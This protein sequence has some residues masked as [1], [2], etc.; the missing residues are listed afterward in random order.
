MS[1][2]IIYADDLDGTEGAETITFALRNQAYEIDLS[3]KNLEKL[4]KALQPFVAAARP[5]QTSARQVTPVLKA[6]GTRKRASSGA[7]AA[8]VEASAVRVWASENNIT[9]PARGRI[10]KPII[11]E[12]LA[13][14][15]S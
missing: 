2:K 15:A 4:E 12:Y 6:G 13:A 7:A 9:I 11:E 3:A 8:G 10:P 14:T 1:Q 5:A